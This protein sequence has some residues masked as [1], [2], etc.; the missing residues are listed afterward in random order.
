MRLTAL[1]PW[2]AGSARNAKTSCWSCSG[3]VIPVEMALTMAVTPAGGL[4]P[5]QCPAYLRCHTAYA[6]R[7]GRL[8]SIEEAGSMTKLPHEL[9]RIRLN[10]ARSKEFPTGSARHGYEFVAPL[11]SSGRI[12][13]RLWH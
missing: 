1:P 12:D 13:P 4:E 3:G 8:R 2:V 10:L 11:D 7:E 5:S 6:R 9:K